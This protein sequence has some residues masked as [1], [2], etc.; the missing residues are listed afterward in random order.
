MKNDN[1]QTAEFCDN[2]PAVSRRKFV[3]MAGA[4]LVVLSL[5]TRLSFAIESVEKTKNNPKIVWILL[6]GALDSLHT[7]VP[8]FEPA[9]KKL[10]P[11]LSSSFK[12][13][14]LPLEKG[15]ALHPSLKNLHQWYQ[16]KSLIPVVAV[17]SGYSKRSHFDGQDF[18][19]SGK[20]EIDHDSGWLA[21]AIEIKNKKAL[22][23][24][25]STPISLRGSKQ[26]NTWYP[27][28]LKNADDDIYSALNQLYQYDKVLKNNLTKGLE[29]KG[30]VGINNSKNKR[31]KGKFVELAKACA[32]LMKEGEGVDCAMIELGGWDTHNNQ[33]NRLEQKLSELDSGLAQ[34]KLGLE[35]E[36]KNTVVIIST[37]FG[38]TVK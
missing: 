22:A 31:K 4:S 7:I 20:H 17:S 9:Y 25:R 32:K 38:H 16:E 3:K 27:S 5:P 34:L 37:E 2:Y 21:R 30:L 10:R 28:T 26:V 15:F 12:S 35:D 23:I 6:R 18:L 24:S 14:L 36:W 19:E 1:K 29:I 11:T 33:S 13:S 8:T